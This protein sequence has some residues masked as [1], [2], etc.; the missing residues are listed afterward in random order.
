V[1]APTTRDVTL[2]TWY[3]TN[4]MN[5]FWVVTPEGLV[6]NVSAIGHLSTVKIKGVH[7][8]RTLADLDH[9]TRRHIHE[10]K[11]HATVCRQPDTQKG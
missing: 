4:K 7:S 3:Q 9:T 6:E 8:S 5:V 2:K 1:G 11:P 10:D